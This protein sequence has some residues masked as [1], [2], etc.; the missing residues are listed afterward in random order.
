MD[1]CECWVSRAPRSVQF[2]TRYGAHDTH[3]PLY[4][5]SGDPVD[6]AHDKEMRRVGKLAVVLYGDRWPGLTEQETNR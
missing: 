5:E 1:G 3:C 6:R 2:R 4:R